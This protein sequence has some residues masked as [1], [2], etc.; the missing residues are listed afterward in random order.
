[1]KLFFLPLVG[2]MI[3]GALAAQNCKVEIGPE[4]KTNGDLYLWNHLYSDAGSHYVLLVEE[5]RGYF[6]YKKFIP[7]LQKYDRAFKLVQSREIVLE[8]SDIMFDDMLYAGQKFVL[9]TNYDNKKAQ[10][11]SINAAVVGLDAAIGQKRQITSLAYDNKDNFPD[12]IKWR[13]SSDTSK[14]LLAAWADNDEEKLQARLFISVLDNNLTEIWQ[15]NYTLPYNQE[16]LKILNVLVSNTG[17]VY[18]TAK[19]YL[20]KKAAKKKDGPE[21]PAY[22]MVVFSMDGTSEKVK[23]VSPEI[24]GKFVTDLS[25]S[26]GKSG[27]LYCGGIYTNEKQG[28]IQGFF[29]QKTNTQTGTNELVFKKELS[30]S[31][32]KPFN[33]RKD[34]QGN[35]GLDPNFEMKNLILREDGGMVILAEEV[36]TTYESYTPAGSSTMKTATIYNTNDVMVA[37]VAPEGTVEWIN[38]V[39]KNQMFGGTEKYSSFALM[40]SGSTLCFIYNDDKDNISKPISTK[41]KPI[42]SFNDAVAAMLTINSNGKA[43]R[44]ILFSIKKDTETLLSPKKCAQISANELFFVTSGAFKLTGKNIYHLGVIRIE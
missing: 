38:I 19:V 24:P 6:L 20:D 17:Q 40:V 32:I 41:A 35:E 37:A 22:R 12:N 43:E 44:Q 11:V 4:F 3:A 30:D 26:T 18:L 21:P 2:I 28:I 33:V 13:V 5:N 10:K 31:D 23:E 7:T 34:K 29:C 39:P 15:Q 16:E 36:F 25:I 42:S 27:E 9:C 8:D 14:I 1:M